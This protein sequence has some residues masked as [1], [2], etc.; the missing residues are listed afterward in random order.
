MARAANRKFD[1]ATFLAEAGPGRRVIKLKPNQA[2][3][4]QG[5]AADCIFYLQSGHVKLTVVSEKGLEATIALLSPGDFIGEESIE[6]AGGPRRASATAIT[7]CLAL[8]IDRDAMIRVMQQQHALSD[9]FLKFLLARSMRNQAD[10]AG[11]LFESSEKRLSRVLML[12]AQLGKL[13]EMPIL[14]ATQEVA[15]S[16]LGAKRSRFSFFINRFRKLGWIDF[17]GNIRLHSALLNVMLRDTLPECDGHKP[18]AAPEPGRKEAVAKPRRRARIRARKP[19]RTPSL[20][21][22]EGS[23]SLT[24]TC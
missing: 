6:E 2:F 17:N 10:L 24:D 16:L 5:A 9:L 13:Q 7:P 18:S 11:Q 3:F 4:P 23:A 21:P 19:K 12:M 22:P 15:T 8:K 14:P 1:P 20:D